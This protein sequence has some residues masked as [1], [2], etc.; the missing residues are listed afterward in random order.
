MSKHSIKSSLSMANDTASV[1]SESRSA[2]S[3]KSMIVYLDENGNQCKEPRVRKVVGTQ[4]R[5]V[6]VI[7]YSR[8]HRESHSRT[9]HHVTTVSFP[10]QR[11]D[12]SLTSAYSYSPYSMNYQTSDAQSYQSSS[13]PSYLQ[14]AAYSPQFHNNIP[15]P[16]FIITSPQHF[17]HATKTNSI[18][19][20][21]NSELNKRTSR[22][23]SH[24]YE[25]S[26][27]LMDKQMELL[28]RKY[29]GKIRAQRAA[30]VIQRAFRR[31]MLN[32]K[33]AS[34]RATANVKT[35]KRSSIASSSMTS[36]INQR[37][38]QSQSMEMYGINY[39]Q[40]HQLQNNEQRSPAT[41][42]AP[43]DQRTL[44]SP[45]SPQLRN[46]IIL[47]SPAHPYVNLMHQQYSAG[48]P[49]ITHQHLQYQNSNNSSTISF[50][51]PIFLDASN[52]TPNQ[53]WNSLNSTPSSPLVTHYTAS[54]IYMR[55]K[56]MQYQQ[57]QS[58]QQQPSPQHVHSSP[59]ATHKKQ[60]PEVPKRMT[61]AVSTGSLKKSNGLSRSAN[62]GSLQSVQSSGSESSASL[63]K[64]HYENLTE[65]GTSPLW[66]HKNDDDDQ[67]HR[68]N[69]ANENY[70]YSEIIR[71]RKYRL[72][73][74]LFN[75][76]PEKGIEFLVKNGFL[77]NTHSGVA[78]F[79]ISR[80]GLSRQMI[81][82]YL[83]MI[84]NSFN[85][86]VLDAFC[87]ELD[88]SGMAVDVALR[89]FQ[90][91]FRMPG[92]A[93]KI[94]RLIQAFSHRYAKCNPEV[95]GK[96]RSSETIFI[97]AFA[98][99]MLNTDLHTQA[100]KPE[101]RMRCED[102]I[103][104]LRGV[105][106]CSDID[107]D[108]LVGIYER[109]KVNEFKP[110]SDH[111]T[112]VMKV[113]ATIIG[114]KP[115]LALPHRRL[116]CYCRLY[117][118]PDLNRKERPGVHQREVFLFNDILVITKIFKKI[119]KTS[120]TYSF[121]TSYALPGMVVTLLKSSNYPHA[122]QLSNRVD[123][124]VLI[125]FNARNEH[126]RCKFAQDLEESIAEMD[127]MEQIRIESEL[128]KQKNSRNSR[129]SKSTSS[130]HHRDS[131]YAEIKHKHK[132]KSSPTANHAQNNK[133]SNSLLNI[134]EQFTGD[135]KYDKN[136]RASVCSLDSG[137]S[138]SFLSSNGTRASDNNNNV[139][140][141]PPTTQKLI[142]MPNSPRSTEV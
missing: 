4:A 85:M 15:S 108:I 113:Q 112:Q 72:G 86:A 133:L 67:S 79:L 130:E 91:Y 9:Q 24:G 78:K 81:G 141:K 38:S 6:T 92:E 131:G 70:K 53:S 115:N 56:N 134:N 116:V 124:K 3:R 98:I 45:N 27:D 60:P 114:K 21:S 30:L 5:H 95:V 64:M 42:N 19:Y 22:N 65:R 44:M 8:R 96:L 84:Q 142:L 1:I 132:T 14:A 41:I 138:L 63:E 123:N 20:G 127:E 135:N 46:S 100:L 75:K 36:S 69:A 51:S 37:L 119:S 94:E 49:T 76:K 62:N 89:K 136:R 140:N 107:R 125:T 47:K 122:I 16:N 126:D 54:Q 66:K 121:R 101:K 68:K 12:R 73:L 117:E 29:G 50:G 120:V 80:K 74:N 11:L 25:L 17:S 59:M 99:I 10:Q 93:Q 71:K 104:N 32:K 139:N 43:Y 23:Q 7:N 111:V 26:Q 35:E 106:D 128:E 129:N 2:S 82:E 31:Y 61:S 33:F 88:L 34:I 48:S 52:T 28:E 18:R 103:K 109:I 39:Q 58:Q 83:G 55:P 118:V 40:Q 87:D 137:T 13:T 90:S 110:A 97:L 77:D 102:F 105:D 57:Q